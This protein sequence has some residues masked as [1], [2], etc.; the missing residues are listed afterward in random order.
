M[1]EQTPTRRFYDNLAKV[2]DLVLSSAPTKRFREAQTVH[3][4]AHTIIRPSDCVLELGSGTG[5]YT[6][7]LCSISRKVIATDFSPSMLGL[8]GRKLSH[9]QNVTIQRADV[10]DFTLKNGFDV[11]VA[12]GVSEHVRLASMLKVFSNS[13]ADRAIYSVPT[14]T[15]MG[16]F[17]RLMYRVFGVNYRLYSLREVEETF[18]RFRNISFRIVD[19]A[20]FVFLPHQAKILQLNKNGTSG[21]AKG[22]KEIGL[23]LS[24]N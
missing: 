3:K 17:I 20:P 2:W 1:S 9:V 18:S 15:I 12:I 14:A 22:G 5:F 23:E 4:A 24:P 13:D 21:E 8:L 6:K 7:H 11:I 16:R 10:N 19:V